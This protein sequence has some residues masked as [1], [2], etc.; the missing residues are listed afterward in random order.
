M[1]TRPDTT[2]AMSVI[3]QIPLAPKMSHWEAVVRILRFLKKTQRKIV[4]LRLL[5]C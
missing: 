4:V 2:F 1:A 5:T 3:S